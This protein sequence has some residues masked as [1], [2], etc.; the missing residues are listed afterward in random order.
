[1]TVVASPS[2]TAANGDAESLLLVNLE[3]QASGRAVVTTQHGGIPEFV[4]A[5][6][7]ALLVPERDPAALADALARVLRDRELATRLGSG[8]PLVAGEFDIAA[9][10]ARVDDLY[11][12]VLERPSS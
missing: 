12:E 7:S 1:A 2:Q 4:A 3:A 10:A 5:N 8:G 11:D 6:A 9:M